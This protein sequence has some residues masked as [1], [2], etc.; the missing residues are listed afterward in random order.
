MAGA[1]DEAVLGLSRTVLL[2]GEAGIGKTRLL[3]DFV[4]ARPEGPALVLRGSCVQLGDR[5]LPYAPFREVLLELCSALS[6]ETV[7]E[8]AGSGAATLSRLVPELAP[9]SRDGTEGELVDVLARL[10]DRVSLERPILLGVEDLHWADASTRALFGY[11]VRAL[12]TSRVLTVG[13]LRS[14]PPPD[15]AVEELLDEL[16]RL[17]HVERLSLSRLSPAGVSR[18]MRGIMAAPP[19]ADMAERVVARSEGVPFLVEELTAAER[20]GN[21]GVPEGLRNLL[22]RRT[23]SLS[24]AATAV[25]RA[26]AASASPVNEA[27]LGAVSGLDDAGLRT[28]LRE[29]VTAHLLVVDRRRGTYDF[30]HALQ[31]EAVEDDLLPGEASELHRKYATL[32]E[33]DDPALPDDQMIRAAHQW[34]LAGDPNRCYPATLRAAAAA[35]RMSAYG[36]EL[37]L[38]ERALSI[39]GAVADP[40][41]S[42]VNDRGD[43]LLAAGR[44]ARLGGRYDRALELLDEG[45]TDVGREDIDRSAELLWEESLLVRSLGEL[46]AVEERLR[47]ALDVA[48]QQPSAARA[49]LLNAL[50]QLQLHRRDPAASQTL[51]DAVV[52]AEGAGESAVAAHLRVTGAMLMA[53]H[54]RETDAALR[55]LEQ[56][57]EIARNQDDVALALR[58]HDARAHVLVASGRPAEAERAAREGLEL[59]A[60]RGSPVFIHDH[61]VGAL[62]D[63]RWATGQW[64]EALSVL[65]DALR[66]DRPDLERAGLYA[67][68]ARLLVAMGEIDL[69][70]AD[71]DAGRQ[72]LDRAEAAPDLHTIVSLAEIELALARGLTGAALDAAHRT[73]TS[74]GDRATVDSVRQLLLVAASATAQ[75]ASTERRTDSRWI[76]AA[77]AE[78]RAQRPGEP[79]DSVLSAETSDGD[80]DCWRQA[81]E[82]VRGPDTP[83]LLRLHTL[84][85]AAKV[86]LARRPLTAADRTAA[87]GLVDEVIQEADHLGA[88]LVASAAR[89]LAL[90]ARLRVND[91]E[92]DDS[93]VPE[94]LTRREAE[95]VR[96]L[97]LGQS[98]AQIAAELVISIKTV[99][100]HVSHVLDKL[101]VSSRGEAAATARARGLA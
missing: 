3:S 8:L 87:G 66:I 60:T 53:D 19:P 4:A 25:L 1:W 88:L 12:R 5:A 17:P 32:L 70:A 80:P 58:V 23:K 34:W 79:W 100:V 40:V 20:A 81:T 47:S 22:L 97:A 2:A 27:T 50:L 59:A 92:P 14:E 76:A 83:A 33:S 42:D 37:F 16:L 44:A 61:L 98:N 6:Q 69:G 39:W 48:A 10:L 45:L 55:Q 85:G 35:R 11:L 77:V 67:R 89:N 95:V 72:R 101:G 82:S 86:R 15:L 7:H 54:P 18:Q 9:S 84:L 52:A 21:Q 46:P 28:P 51:H 99:S 31:R 36:E 57:G 73:Y 30:R 71:A 96:L 62:V 75:D 63:A 94:G 13:T 38:L 68:R 91:R 93:P 49:R 65:D 90:R 24:G 43:L 29:L 41:T 56:A 78:L 64:A 74:Y 26:A